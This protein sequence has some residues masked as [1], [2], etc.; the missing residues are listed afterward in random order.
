M[1]PRYLHTLVLIG[2]LLSGVPALAQSAQDQIVQTLRNQGYTRI[3]VSRTW[4]GRVR[5]HAES[6]FGEREIVFN[7]KTGAIL[8][9]YFEDEN[10][11]DDYDDDDDHNTSSGSSSGSSSSNSGSGSNDDDDDDDRDDNDDDDDSDDDEED[12]DDE[13]DHDDDD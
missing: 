2:A 3:E 5:V 6:P 8:R 10:D 9:D 1:V 11:D 7:P 12:D 13:D 4:L